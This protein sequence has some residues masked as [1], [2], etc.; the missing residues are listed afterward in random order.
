[1][2]TTKVLISYRPN[3]ENCNRREIQIREN[4]VQ[5]CP[6]LFS[7]FYDHTWVPGWICKSYISFLGV[8][9]VLKVWGV[10]NC[11]D[12]IFFDFWAPEYDKKGSKMPKFFLV[13]FMTIYEYLPPFSSCTLHFEGWRRVCRICGVCRVKNYSNSL[14]FWFLS[15]G[16]F[17]KVLQKCPQFFSVFYDCTWMLGPIF[18]SCASFFREGGGWSHEKLL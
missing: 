3:T 7:M 6:N 11:C 1:M 8:E 15:T 10:E 4:V 16:I 18:K 5:K 9:G 13:R 12:F 2:K 17:E 14:F